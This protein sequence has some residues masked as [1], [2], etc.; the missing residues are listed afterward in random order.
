M[1]KIIKDSIVSTFKN[2]E[3][4]FIS[5]FAGFTVKYILTRF[6]PAHTQSSY[7]IK[8]LVF[9]LIALFIL[10]GTLASLLKYKKSR[11]WNWKTYVFEGSRI[12]PFA[13]ISSIGI[14]TL[15]RLVF[16][17]VPAGLRN[18]VV[19]DALLIILGCAAS[20]YLIGYIDTGSLRGSAGNMLEIL[21]SRL[22]AW[23]GICVFIFAM[24]Y[25]TRMAIFNIMNVVV[26]SDNKYIVQVLVLLSEFIRSFM[27]VAILSTLVSLTVKE[28]A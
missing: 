25:I 22:P 9:T 13:I 3:L 16:L 21:R 1:Q 26:H 15:F 10:S 19:M 6:F 12:L 28:N 23:L 7:I 24:I 14:I 5:F 11:S 27:V 2:S 17:L 20:M 4:I 8:T 18:P